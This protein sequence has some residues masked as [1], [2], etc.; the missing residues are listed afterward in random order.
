MQIAKGERRATGGRAV[1]DQAKRDRHAERAAR[2][3]ATAPTRWPAN[4]SSSTSTRS[5]ASSKAA[6]ERVR[7]VLYPTDEGEAGERRGGERADER[8]NGGRARRRAA[9]RGPRASASAAAR[10]C[11]ASPSRCSA[12]EVVG[13]LGPNGAGK[14]T[15]FYCHRRPHAPGRRQRCCSTAP[16]SPREPM[17]RARPPGHQLPAA[18]A[19]GVP[20]A[21]RRGEHAGDPRDPAAH[22]TRSAA[23]GW[24]SCSRSSSI[25]H[26]AKNK[27]YTLSGGERRRVEITRALVTAPTFMLLDEPFAGIDPIA[28]L[29]IQSIVAQL[30]ERG[31]G[32]LDHRPQ[33]AR[34]AWNLRPS[35]YPQRRSD[36]GGGHTGGDRRE[37]AARELYLG[38]A[39]HPV[40]RDRWHSKPNSIRS[41]SQQLVMTPQLRQAI[42][43]LQVS[44]AELETAGRRG[45]GGEPG[46]RGGPRADARSRRRSAP[47]TEEQ[48]EADGNERRRVVGAAATSARP[49]TSSSRTSG[50]DDIDWKEYLDNYSNDWHGSSATP[51]DYDDEKRPS[52][53]EHAGARASR[54]P[55]T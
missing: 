24:P 14:T 6:T 29:D 1:F 4:A 54:S 3:A 53:R 2:A 15:T 55:S 52:A 39:L 51:A 36:S 44:R 26:L 43:I 7:A 31:I 48:L 18:G 9:R 47:R 42:K 20:Q 32:M 33:R 10:S 23:S 41:S 8:P 35:V 5:A 50:L 30:Q 49:P 22:A 28:V 34:D 12:G 37:P 40:G 19:V 25:A 11:A 46:A 21:H 16:T 27:A 13:L 38:R 17:Y 45:A